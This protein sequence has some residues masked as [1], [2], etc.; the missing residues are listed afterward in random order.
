MQLPPCVT[1]LEG[2]LNML[3]IAAPRCEMRRQKHCKKALTLSQGNSV[4]S[5]CVLVWWAKTISRLEGGHHAIG[6]F[7]DPIS[8]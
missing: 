2:P 6:T 8:C 4:D 1:G 5:F 3:V 7:W